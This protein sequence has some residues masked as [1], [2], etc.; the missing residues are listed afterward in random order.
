MKDDESPVSRQQLGVR[1]DTALVVE[2]KV[3]AARQQRRLNDLVEEA[4][5][6]L[7]KKYR[8]KFKGK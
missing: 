3:L 8:E 5:R 1:I 4:L 6:D 7:L 2:A